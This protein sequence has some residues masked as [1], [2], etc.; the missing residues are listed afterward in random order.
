MKY[1]VIV[2]IDVPCYKKIVV[3]AASQEDAEDIALESA[4]T[5]L[6]WFDPEWD[7]GGPPRVA[8]CECIEIERDPELE[9][10]PT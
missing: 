10:E 9:R 2:A 7:A 5:S 8:D 1:A 3:E 4:F 6:G